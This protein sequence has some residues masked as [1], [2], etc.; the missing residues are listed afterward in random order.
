V[1]LPGHRRTTDAR[2]EQLARLDAA[3]LGQL[4][5]VFAPP[6]WLRDLGRAS[7][8]LVGV[9][10]LIA[11][12]I[13]LLGKTSVIVGPVLVGLV[14]ATVAAPL[15]T[16]LHRRRLPRAVG[17]LVVLLGLV[18]LGVLVLVLVLAGITA[19]SEVISEHATAAAD[20]AEAWLKDAGVD[21]DG[22]SSAK[23]NVSSAVPGIISTLTRGVL[24]GI[25]GIT[26]LAFGLSFAVFSIFFLLK[27]G[28]KLR[29]WVEHHL[30]VPRPVAQVITGDV[31]TS[32]R[33]YF[34]GVTIVAAFNGTVVG[35][36]ALFLGVPLAGTIAVVTLVTAYVPFIGAFVSGA[37]A[38]VLALGAEGTSTALIMLA[39]V[40]L[41]NGMLQNIVQPFALGAT[42]SLNPL[43]ILVVTIGAGSLFGMV[44]MVLAAPLTSALVHITADLAHVRGVEQVPEEA[45]TSPAPG[46]A[47]PVPA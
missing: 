42:L 31:I 26:S 19:Q 8:L 24:D 16:A 29:R 17:A 35:L 1:N 13:W 6:R 22:S 43:L 40:L 21:S 5:S 30:G 28:P 25:E 20:K 7:W 10:A 12:L 14:V 37:F 41:A 44:G 11:A 2:P 46:D 4:A 9:A 45:E 33:R 32:V 27:D 38:V 23:E 39:I 15:V 18:A 34:L 3:E 36:G 47:P